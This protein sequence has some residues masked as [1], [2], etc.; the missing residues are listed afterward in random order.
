MIES[1]CSV[2]SAV[3]RGMAAD[4][5]EDA[6][7]SPLVS[8]RARSRSFSTIYSMLLRLLLGIAGTTFRASDSSR[9]FAS[10]NRELPGV[11][12]GKIGSR[13]RFRRAAVAAVWRWRWFSF[14]PRQ[15]SLGPRL[16]CVGTNDTRPRPN[17]FRAPCPV[18]ES[19]VVVLSLSP[20]YLGRFGRTCL[21]MPTLLARFSV[22]PTKRERTA[23]S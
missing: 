17:R 20:F 2:R 11:R 3:Y 14:L 4:R 9:W 13:R 15:P 23:G 7:V 18:K 10:R 16:L 8:R 22:F 12:H 21:Y 1:V 5:L 19:K 6:S